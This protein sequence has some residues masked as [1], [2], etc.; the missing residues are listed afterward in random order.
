MKEICNYGKNVRCRPG[1]SL[2]YLDASKLENEGFTH[3]YKS[4]VLD[5]LFL[6]KSDLP[7]VT[8]YVYENI[9]KSYSAKGGFLYLELGDDT[10]YCLL[11]SDTYSIAHEEIYLLDG[12]TENEIL[13]ELRILVDK[14]LAKI[15][16][17]VTSKSTDSKVHDFFSDG[18]VVLNGKKGSFIK[19]SD[20]ITKLKFL[21]LSEPLCGSTFACQNGSDTKTEFKLR[22]I[23]Q[24]KS[25]KLKTTALPIFAILFSIAYFFIPDSHTSQTAAVAQIVPKV[26][27]DPF[28][29]YK[30]VIAD[31]QRVTHIEPALAQIGYAIGAFEYANKRQNEPLNW[32]ITSVKSSEEYNKAIILKPASIGG[33]RTALAQFAEYFKLPLMST[34]S[35]LNLAIGL[36]DASLRDANGEFY[37][38]SLDAEVDY[39]TDSINFLEDNVTIT[40]KNRAI[41]GSG[42]G[43]F[44][45]GLVEI[46]FSCWLP[47]DFIFVATQFAGR[48]YSFN[49]INATAQSVEDLANPCGFTGT[50]NIEVFSKG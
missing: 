16:L 35:G 39:I 19:N 15:G 44:S 27:I 40:L 20:S 12:G 9:F 47:R 8:A 43:A 49:S 1:R 2:S 11:I 17:V 23:A 33:S 36:N 18:E 31:P 25:K 45:T 38:R 32:V 42:D 37:H 10:L 5:C 7:I 3:F 26:E 50:I 29:E 30:K 28:H 48:Q 4:D 13:T 41:S 21:N 14:Y 46:G 6:S 34:E 24:L 22:S